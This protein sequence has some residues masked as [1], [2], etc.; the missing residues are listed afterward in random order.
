M[1]YLKCNVG[2]AASHHRIEGLTPPILLRSPVVALVCVDRS[3]APLSVMTIG[4]SSRTCIP[5][6]RLRIRR[7]N[8]AYSLLCTEMV[9]QKS[10][11]VADMAD[12]DRR[13]ILARIQRLSP[14]DACDALLNIRPYLE[15][16]GLVYTHLR[17]NGDVLTNPPT[18]PDD[19]N[20]DYLDIKVG[21]TADIDV[22]RASSPKLIQRLTH[23]T[24]AYIGAKRV[25]YPCNGCRVRHREHFSEG[26]AALDVVALTIEYWIR[27]IGETPV[28]FAMYELD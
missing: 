12:D 2:R 26:C 15:R 18:I 8:S 5:I 19:E 11:A 1:T 14:S 21:E 6:D 16:P 4:E 17:M 20:L 10:N 3:P 25:P 23:L 28:R 9:W 22:R 24:L 27:K 7:R 13:K